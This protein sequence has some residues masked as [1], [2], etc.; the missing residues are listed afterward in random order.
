MRAL[1]AA[2]SGDLGNSKHC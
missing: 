2:G 1:C